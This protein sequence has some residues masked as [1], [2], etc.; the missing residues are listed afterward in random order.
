MQP[1]LTEGE[2]DYTGK[3]GKKEIVV[4]SASASGFEPENVTPLDGNHDVVDVDVEFDVL[5]FGPYPAFHPIPLSTRSPPSPSISPPHFRRHFPAR[6]LWLWLR[7]NSKRLASGSTSTPISISNP[8][9]LRLPGS[10]LRGST[11]RSRPSP[12]DWEVR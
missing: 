12:Q 1:N 6:P 10:H 4:V 5:R 9:L 11:G 8:S 2:C 7:S 3:S